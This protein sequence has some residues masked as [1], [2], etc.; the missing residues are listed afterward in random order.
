MRVAFINPNISNRRSR[1]AMQ[2]LAFA[3]LQSLTP[4]DVE[5]V[6]LDERIEDVD[7]R[8]PCDAVAISVQSFTAR[9]AYEIA[10]GFRARG[11]PVVLG[12]HHPTL[13]PQEAAEYCDS[14]AVG[15]GERCWP[16]IIRDLLRG[17]LKARYEPDD[18]LP[19][20]V[21]PDRSIFAGK[22]YSMLRP[23]QFG[24]GCR[25]SC[26]F[27]SVN[28]LYGPTPY[29]RSIQSVMEEIDTIQS[30]YLLFVD[31]NIL[32]NFND[33]M[34]LFATL[35]HKRRKWA[36]QISI[37]SAF[38]PDMVES[39]ADA[40][41]IAVFVGLESLNPDNLEEIGKISNLKYQD[42]GEA[43]RR[44]KKRGIMFCGSFVFGY[45]NDTV[46]T[47]ESSYAFAT[48]T[49]MCIAH[50][51]TLFPMPGTVLYD[52]LEREERLRFDRWWLDPNFRFGQGMFY[53]RRISAADLG[54]T[55]YRMRRR[56]NS[57]ANI[58][59]R[60]TDRCANSRNLANTGVFIAANL[61][62]RKEIMR[63]QHIKLGAD[64]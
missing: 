7:T 14:V 38:N 54:K 45:E 23:I 21:I 26:D 6:L 4:P 57:V 51:N 30:R 48:K 8:F 58:L 20:D 10:A 3:V 60:L 1:D 62:S 50:F 52:R 43:I 11:I 56:F 16:N 64:R 5:T 41:C 55:C 40:G 32:L 34:E 63:K 37:D 28:T 25:Y 42:Y 24:R 9:R 44:F 53:P 49:R 47:I 39:M 59:Y 22:G 29:Q 31:D 2:P 36:C 13:L 17:A 35:K 12:G 27:C 15:E 61:I 33:T 18:S 46:E 19:R